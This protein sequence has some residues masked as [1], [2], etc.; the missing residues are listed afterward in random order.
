[1][2]MQS[3]SEHHAIFPPWKAALVGAAVFALA[4]LLFWASAAARVLPADSPEF[5]RGFTPA[6]GL[7]QLVGG[8]F[9]TGLFGAT[10]AALA[11]VGCNTARRHSRRGVN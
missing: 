11:A 5:I 3:T 8:M 1:M 2:A 7:Q 10:I 4:C 6:A 9:W